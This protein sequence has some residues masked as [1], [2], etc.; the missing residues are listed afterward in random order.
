MLWLQR[1]VSKY[2]NLLN[3]IIFVPFSGFFRRTIRSKQ[4]Y[5]CRFQQRCSID[6]GQDPK[7]FLTENLNFSPFSDQ[8]NACRFCRFQ[9]C[10]QVG[11]EITAIRPDRD[12]IGK[13]KNP[14]KRKLLLQAKAEEG[15]NSSGGGGSSRRMLIKGEGGES[16]LPSPGTESNRYRVQIFFEIK[17][18][19]ASKPFYNLKP[20][21]FKR[22]FF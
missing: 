6:K 14:R 3:K 18:F 11:M 22:I 8:R 19:M 10:L 5:N 15:A 13:Q 17:N 21:E 12:V 20:I 1:Q 7:F 16:C 2:C 9:R 4:S